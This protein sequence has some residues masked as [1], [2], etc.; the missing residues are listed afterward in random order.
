MKPTR[1][2]TNNY[3]KVQFKDIGELTKYENQMLEEIYPKNRGVDT[4]K[5]SVMTPFGMME[6]HSYKED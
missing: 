4:N 1:Q 5:R 3:V 2:S 6:N